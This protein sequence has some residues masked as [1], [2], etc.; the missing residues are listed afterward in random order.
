LELIIVGDI[1]RHI[2]GLSAS[3]SNE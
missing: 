3:R 2:S 1:C